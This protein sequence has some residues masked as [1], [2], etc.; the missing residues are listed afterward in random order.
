V[1]DPNDVPDWETLLAH[2]AHLQTKV[3]GAILVGGT[4]AAL[5]VK[6]RYSVDHDQEIKNLGGNYAEALASLE[7]IAGWKTHR[8][9]HGKEV[10]GEVEGIEAGLRNQRRSAPLET[11]EVT[12]AGGAKLVVPT[13]EEMLRVKAFLTV[14]RNATRDE[15][16]P[17]DNCGAPLAGEYCGACGQRRARRLDAARVLR[18]GLG[19]VLDADNAW[20]TTLRELTLRPGP[21][22]RRYVAGERKRFVNPILYMLSAATVFLVVFKG[23]GIDIGSVQGATADEAANLGFLMGAIGYLV[24]IG[25]LPVAWAMTLVLRQ[26]TTGELYVLLVYGY[27]QIALLQ[28][29]L[30]AL[31]AADSAAAFAASRLASAFVYSWVLAGYFAWRPV[32]ALLAGLLV[33]G[34][35]MVTLMGVGSGVIALRVVLA[36]LLG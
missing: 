24:L 6:H 8:R 29:L 32:R 20:W 35:L 2:A 30:Y 9:V 18:E 4:A 21:T 36:H 15:V 34:A 27:A 16:G 7:S 5:H 11:V 17:C 3:P 1:A 23:L 28:S 25:A 10:L 13:V 33:Y 22:V 26:Q 12:L 31:G 19:Q 14:Q